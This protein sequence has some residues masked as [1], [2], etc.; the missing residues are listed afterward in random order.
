MY[1]TQ[2]TRRRIARALCHQRRGRARKILS[3]RLNQ[4]RGLRAYGACGA[5]LRGV[6]AF[7]D[8][9]RLSE[10]DERAQQLLYTLDARVSE[11]LRQLA[12]G[13][14]AVPGGERL[15]DGAR[16]FGE[17]L[18]PR[19][20]L[21]RGGGGG[22]CVELFAEGGGDSL[23]G[24]LEVRAEPAHRA[25]AFLGGA[26]CVEADEAFED[27]FVGERGGP[28]V[29][30]EDGRVEFVVNLAEDG[31]EAVRVRDALTLAERLVGKFSLFACRCVALLAKRF[32]EK[33]LLGIMMMDNVKAYLGE[34]MR[35]ININHKPFTVLD[36]FCGCGGL[37]LGFTKAG[38]KVIRAVDNNEAALNTYNANFDSHAIRLDLSRSVDLPTASVIIGGPPCQGFSSAGLRKVNDH[39]NSLVSGFAEI[40]SMLRPTA[41]VFENVE[42]FLT[43]ED[44]TRVL[45]L[46]KP[47]IETGYRIHVRKVNAANYGVPQHRKRVIAIGG[48]GWNPSVPEP[49]HAAFGAPGAHL[50]TQHAAPTPTVSDAISDLPPAVTEPPGN[51]P[52]H[53]YRPL[54]GIDLLRASALKPGQV[55]RDLPEEL[56]HESYRKRAFRRVMDGT[57]TA[58]RGGAPA[59]LRRLRPDEPSK[60]ITG[61]AR[62]EF[63]HP[64]ENR[65]LTIRECA[66]LQTFPDGFS[67]C[68][69]ASEQAQ[70][71]GNAVP[72]LLAL[73]IAIN[74]AKDLTQAERITAEGALL[75][76]VPTL[77]NG[78]SPAL[79]KV[80][81]MVLATFTATPAPKPEQLRICL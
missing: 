16:L 13:D 34:R 42:G 26:L 37:S 10:R 23:G 7:A 46:L 78:Y 19:L 39:R 50:A 31:D 4:L 14:D 81:D 76:F 15:P 71:I 38:F 3:A 24:F 47:L 48:L 51:P 35:R 43:A 33:D 58:R 53:Y 40:V 41:F 52:G 9:A 73:A 49:T 45:E 55:M 28:A 2:K 70:L 72:P 30:V 77:S 69:N 36:L 12:R 68:G 32:Y 20:F 61:G 59:G 27:F 57:P 79:R 54:E 21:A 67:F 17:R 11:G 62:S 18:G 56:Q 75:S 64:V 1:A 29:G 6:A 8:L 5:G 66:R 60:A 22:D 65:P 74:L 44:G 80:T 25:G 63:I